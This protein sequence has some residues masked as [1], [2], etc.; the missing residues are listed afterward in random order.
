MEQESVGLMIESIKALHPA[1]QVAFF[2]QMSVKICK[3]IADI[4]EKQK[5]NK[6]YKRY[7]QGPMKWY[8]KCLVENYLQHISPTLILKASKEVTDSISTWPEVYAVWYPYEKMIQ[9]KCISTKRVKMKV[10]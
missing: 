8:L 1:G 10:N 3:Q 9:K 2:T 5:K 7:S 6:S 4:K